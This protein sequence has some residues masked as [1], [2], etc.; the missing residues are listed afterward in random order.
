M[1][2]EQ[3]IAAEKA[4]ADASAA[5][6]Q[7]NAQA[8]AQA[9]A[10]VADPGASFRTTTEKQ[11]AECYSRIKTLEAG[12]AAGLDSQ[13][14]SLEGK[15]RTF[16]SRILATETVQAENVSSLLRMADAM[17]AQ[18]NKIAALEARVAALEAAP[19]PAQ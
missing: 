11:I 13:G 12:G 15:I 4:L 3:Q 10:A 9:E 6:E 17:T 5:L 18:A 7:A 14:N 1:K 19:K 2:T 16:E 8:T